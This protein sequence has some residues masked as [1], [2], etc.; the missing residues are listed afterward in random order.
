VRPVSLAALLVMLHACDCGG[1]A[2]PD[3]GIDGGRDSASEAGG[4]AATDTALPDVGPMAEEAVDLLLESECRYAALCTDNE[5][6]HRAYCHPDA[7]RRN[8]DARI[9]AIARGELSVDPD[10]IDACR[11]AAEATTCADATQGCQSLAA[12]RESGETCVLTESCREGL[13]TGTE[14]PTTC[15][16]GLGEGEICAGPSDCARGLTCGSGGTCTPRTAE[17]DACAGAAECIEGTICDGVC[18][19]TTT[20]GPDE[21][22]DVAARCAG[23]LSC[24]GGTC[25]IGADATEAC[26]VDSPCR[27]ETRCED[28]V[29]VERILPD[30]PCGDAALCPRSHTCIEGVC[31]PRPIAGQPCSDDS[32]CLD[33]LC[34]DG[35]CV[36]S[37]A[38]ALC[39]AFFECRSARCNAGVC[40]SEPLLGEPCV[41]PCGDGAVCRFVPGEPRECRP[42]CP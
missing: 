29:C 1:N 37:E 4:D 11:R 36:F 41:G 22:C 26:D 3:G 27:F 13:C 35:V 39:D 16:P 21:P 17:G 2:S 9:R 40:Q 33:G 31:E 20:A 25:M 7:Q 5:S 23:W 15:M 42:L 30:S 12:D 19:A 38:A 10:A 24:R 32:P 28:G 18:R 34:T 14:C 6:Q 8:R